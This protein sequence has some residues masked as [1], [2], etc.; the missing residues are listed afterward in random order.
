MRLLLAKIVPSLLRR[1]S[2]HVY[3]AAELLAATVHSDQIAYVDGAR[4]AEGKRRIF[5]LSA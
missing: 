3:F 2:K 5:D 4:I 1:M